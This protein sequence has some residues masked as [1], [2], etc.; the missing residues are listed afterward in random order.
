MPQI[1]YYNGTIL[2]MEEPFT[3]VEAV[4]VEDGLVKMAGDMAE[5]LKAAGRDAERI[6]LKGHTMIP[7][8]IDSHSHITA[9]AQTFGLQSLAE[10]KSFDD[11]IAELKAFRDRMKLAGGQ[12]IMGYG[13]DHNFL[14]EKRHPDKFILDRY[15]PDNPVLLTHASGHMGVAGSMALKALGVDEDTKDPDGGMIGRVEG[16]MEPDGYLEETAFTLGCTAVPRPSLE[17]LEKQ[18]A[19]AEEAY[20][21]NGITTMQDGITREME[22]ELLSSLASRKGLKADIVS[23]IDLK[24]NP[25]ILKQQPEYRDNYNNHLKIGGY[26]IFL[27]GSPQGRTAWLREPYLGEEEYRGY[28]VYEDNEVEEFFLQALNAGAQL[29]VHGNGD[30]AAEQMI[31]CYRSALEK[32]KNSGERGR[33]RNPV[34]IHAQMV[35]RD[36][37][38]HMRQLGIS[39]SFFTAH[40]YYWGDIHMKNLGMERAAKISPARTAIQE[41][42]VYTFHQDAPVIMPDMIETLWCAVNRITRNGVVL[43]EDERISPYEALK[44]ITINGAVQY[45]EQDKKGT[46]EPG[47]YADLVILDRNPLE[48]KR[49]DIKKIQVL[50]TIK[51]G[52]TVYH[53]S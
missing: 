48:I 34:M 20:L 1:L 27:D 15:F 36:Q 45:G 29:L 19:L 17:Q 5:L 37:L 51:E 12:W 43:G 30:Q 33:I 11:I 38:A 14:K 23:Y 44:G 32:Y 49:S 8:F 31:N 24:L 2:T 7:A 16:T 28:P 13:Y 41:D 52:K 39:A 42:V 10:A 9:L 21:K 50:E 25:E 47:K 4:L 35:R 26:K 46:I 6:D 40:T 18:Y 3:Q 22:W 53:R